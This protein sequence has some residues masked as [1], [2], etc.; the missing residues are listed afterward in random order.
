MKI[1]Y[2]DRDCIAVVKPVGV[3][4]EGG[5]GGM[6]E[7]LSEYCGN[8]VYCVHRLDCA[9]SGVIVYAKNKK[10]AAYFSSLIADGKMKKEYLA[11]VHG[12]VC[13][14]EMTDLLFKDSKANKSYVVK[15]MRKGVKEAKLEY[16]TLSEKDGASL[17]GIRLITGRSHQIRVQFSS[18]KHPLY[19]D[20][21]YG[22]GDRCDIA[23]FSNRI[24]FTDRFGKEIV[25]EA[26][27]EKVYP[28]DKFFDENPDKA[29]DTE[30]RQND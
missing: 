11:V 13:G 7:A 29:E 14:G 22:G 6:V 23:L 15:R 5:V 12:K 17:V 24:S 21:K 4:S 18:R 25:I 16:E 19:G 10:S 27:P 20:G 8:D 9:V 3:V 28:W 1:L 2:E 26:Y 30:S